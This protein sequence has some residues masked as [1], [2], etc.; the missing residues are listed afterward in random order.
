MR[1]ALPAIRARGAELVVIGSGE[2]Y[3][4]LQFRDEQDIDFPLLVDPELRAYAAAGL[5]RGVMRTV[6]PAA[7]R[8]AIRALR[9]R[10]RQ[11]RIRGNAWQLG[12]VFVIA[13]G[14][15]VLFEQRSE[16]AGGH[17]DL[18]LV[19]AALDLYPVDAK[20]ETAE[21]VPGDER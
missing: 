15:R 12:G 18:R 17:A 21:A 5:R 19:V 4:A 10:F 7:I 8:H 16:A 14:D 11:G 13:P 3:Q 20:E 6:G 2:P 1:D 9:G